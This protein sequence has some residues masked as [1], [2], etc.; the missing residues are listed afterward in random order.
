[1]FIA[2]IEQIATCRST[3]V[4]SE[5]SKSTDSRC[6]SGSIELQYEHGKGTLEVKHQKDSAGIK[7]NVAKVKNK[8]GIIRTTLEIEN[9][10]RLVFELRIEKV[11]GTVQGV[12]DN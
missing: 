8:G 3:H 7:I 2:G 5:T 11:E 1:L 10:P 4:L 12:F 6:G 9:E